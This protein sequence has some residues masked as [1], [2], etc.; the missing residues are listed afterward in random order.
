[1][2]NIDDFGNAEKKMRFGL[3][4]ANRETDLKVHVGIVHLTTVDAIGVNGEYI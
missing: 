3:I 1:M 4:L 2:I